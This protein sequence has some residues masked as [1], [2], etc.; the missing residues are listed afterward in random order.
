MSLEE[1]DHF[2]CPYCGQPNGLAV[3]LSGGSSQKFVVDCEVCCAPV[4]VHIRIR[5]G[6]IATLDI[7]KENE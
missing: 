1:Y 4:A 7:K 5:N 2:L 3:D 6:E